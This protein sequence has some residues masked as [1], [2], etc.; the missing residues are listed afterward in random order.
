VARFGYR[1][2][3][4]EGEMSN[5]NCGSLPFELYS[6]HSRKKSVTLDSANH[7]KRNRNIFRRLT[8]RFYQW[9]S[10]T[11]LG[12]PL[13]LVMY[14]QGLLSYYLF[15]TLRKTSKACLYY[16]HD[17][18][19]FPAI[20]LLCRR[21][22]AQFVYDA[23]DFYSGI[24]ESKRPHLVNK[25][26]VKLETWCIKNATEVV[27]VS[28]GIAKMH[29]KTFGRRPLV[30]RNCQ[31][32]RLDKAP[33]EDLRSVLRLNN[34]DFLL[35]LV[36]QAKMGQALEELFQAMTILPSSV[37]LALL[38]GGYE[39]YV[40]R[41][42][43]L[44]LQNRVHS[45]LPVKPFEVV[46]FIKTADAALIV[47]YSYSLNYF[48]CLPNGFFQPIAAELPL[49][50]SDLPEI[51]KIAEKYEL[52]FPI[53]PQSPRSIVKAVLKLIGNP[54]CLSFFKQNA[55]DASQALSWEWEEEKLRNLVQKTINCDSSQAV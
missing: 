23:H 10:R 28:D 46:P 17:F 53:N 52:G 20:Y 45:V 49:I 30:V 36:G 21:Y 39:S 33:V 11:K 48:Y 19:Q 25:F 8:S 42:D 50:Y 5:L 41:I 15:P 51:R 9:L 40:E 32:P 47:Y 12:E 43:G 34:S 3:V 44:E 13:A 7:Q 6:L 31:D 38:G 54:D 4:F 2:I 1:S 18:R 24:D 22:H 37:H 55:R 27:T 29:L 16:L 26:L 14:L 35:V